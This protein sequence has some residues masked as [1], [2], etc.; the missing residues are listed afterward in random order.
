MILKGEVFEGMDVFDSATPRTK[1][2]RNQRKEPQV[3]QRMMR[4]SE[5]VEPEETSY[6]A[7][8]ELRGTRNV[9]DPPSDA[10]SP[11]R[12]SHVDIFTSVLTSRSYGRLLLHHQER[13][14]AAAELAKKTL[15]ISWS[16]FHASHPRTQSCHHFV[17][18][19]RNVS[20][21]TNPN[22]LHHC[23]LAFRATLAPRS[24]KGLSIHLAFFYILDLRQ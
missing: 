24:R 5:E 9:Y 3:M 14:E 12:V 18:I 15:A 20:R 2:R 8:G 17:R 22:M 16:N 13:E 11:V 10:S 7:S 1:R 4:Y 6:L 19:P 23:S 21:P